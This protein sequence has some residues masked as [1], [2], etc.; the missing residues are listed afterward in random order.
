MIAGYKCFNKGLKNRYG[1]SFEIGITYHATGEIKFG[2][3]GNGFHM[4]L[5]L[6][7]TL[8]Y[9]DGMNDEIEICEVYGFGEMKEH[10]DDYNEYYNLYATEYMFI[11]R[12]LT[13]EEIINEMLKV[14]IHRAKRFIM[15]FR[16]TKDEIELFK[17]KFK[18][19]KMIYDAIEYYQKND[20][21]VYAKMIDEMDAK[22]FLYNTLTSENVVD[23]ILNNLEKLLK[24]IPEIK[25]MIGFPHNNPN[26]HLDVW[27]HT[28]LALSLSEN[29]FEIRLC[30]LL[31][32]I[33]KP[34]SYQDVDDI[35]HFRNHQKISKIISENILK[36]LEFDQKFIEEACY[37]IENHD[38]PLKIE[39]IKNDLELSIKRYK[40]QYGDAL[41]HHPD[42]LEKREEYLA[43]TRKMIN[44]NEID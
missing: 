24:I 23:E 12:I 9:F 21:K 15:G 22:E 42:K 26:H 1:D 10:S 35:R 14:D 29:D 34:F 38:T 2:N 19:E 32:D 28:L 20:K 37:L 4:C 39:D 18:N 33:G 27:K 36:R 44:S 13:R 7:D 16:L 41:A 3:N 43:R 30:L 31:H 40:T 25:G 17:S 5:N 11:N 8:R 6:E